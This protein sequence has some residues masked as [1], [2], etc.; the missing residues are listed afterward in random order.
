MY[1]YIYIYTLVHLFVFIDLKACDKDATEGPP[2][3]SYEFDVHRRGSSQAWY[4]IKIV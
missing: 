1:I 3:T 4:I 2:C